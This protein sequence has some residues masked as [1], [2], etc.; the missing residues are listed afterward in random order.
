[1]SRVTDKHK[2]DDEDASALRFGSTFQDEESQTAML[3]ISEVKLLLENI[4]AQ[5]KVPDSTVYNKTKEYVE[6]FAR[7]HDYEV[8]Q[9]VR[10]SL[11]QPEFQSY[12]V[13]Q[14]INLC[15]MESEEAKALIPS[16]KVDDEPLQ[17]HLDDLAAHRKQQ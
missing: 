9:T 3:T 8:V 6:T 17:Q 1:M 16:I 14:M 2:A 7:F 5:G 15:P 13:V 4:E 12:E 11:P 10:N